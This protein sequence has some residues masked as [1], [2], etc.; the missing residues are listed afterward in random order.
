MDKPL[1]REQIALPDGVSAWCASV[2][3]KRRSLAALR[4]WKPDLIYSHGVHSPRVETEM[5]NIAPSVF[6][7]HS[8]HGTCI[9]GGK[10]F[11]TAPATPCDRRFGWGCLLHY[12]PQRC[13]GLNPI[14]MARLF[15][16]QTKRLKLLHSY[17]AILTNSSH[18]RDEYIKHGLPPERVL[19]PSYYARDALE[20]TKARGDFPFDPGD[21]E[22]PNR[23]TAP[24]R[25]H[26]IYFGRVEFLKGG[27]LLIDALP[28][29]SATL[30]RPLQVTFAGAGRDEGKWKRH[31]ARIQRSVK[32]LQVE[33]T[34]WLQRAEIDDLLGKADLLVVPSLWPEPFGLV[35]PEA[36]LH[37]VPV[38]AFDV[39]GVR[40]WLIDGVNGHLAPGNPPTASG[41]A[42]AVVKCLRDPEAHNRLRLGA[43]QVA[44]QFNL[45]NHLTALIEIFEKVLSQANRS[46]R[47]NAVASEGSSV[48]TLS[49][50]V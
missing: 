22:L 10:T 20:T 12:Y 48:A 27:L 50:P 11:K 6:F 5:L 28:Q 40:E 1:N 30:G 2:L 8:Y 16:L 38:A 9:S 3:G 32:D 44:R 36:G 47:E 7:A 41:L 26:L 15:Q 34:G 18:M 45:T 29:I 43:V 42:E 4:D 39:G 14:T 23:T 35:G 37:G 31:A 19:K 46:T 33:F 17:R 49:Q 25:Y 24:G 13:G 21:S